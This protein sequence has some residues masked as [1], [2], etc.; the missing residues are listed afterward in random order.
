MK[1][2]YTESINNLQVCGGRKK[3]QERKCKS[4]NQHEICRN[5]VYTASQHIHTHTNIHINIK[6]YIW[7]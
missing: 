5:V 1:I 7:N 2:I 3:T 6:R 4:Q